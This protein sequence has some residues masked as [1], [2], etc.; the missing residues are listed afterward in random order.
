MGFKIADLCVFDQRV[1][2]EPQW[3][4]WTGQHRQ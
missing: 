2:D 4:E 3:G 1:G